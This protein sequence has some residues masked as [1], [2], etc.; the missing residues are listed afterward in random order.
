M[1]TRVI[2]TKP[3]DIAQRERAKRYAALKQSP[4]D[5]DAWLDSNAA[6]VPQIKAVLKGLVQAVQALIEERR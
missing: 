6:T 2:A 4:E 5:L 1:P 3:A